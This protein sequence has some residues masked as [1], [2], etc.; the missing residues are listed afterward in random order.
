MPTKSELTS[1]TGLIL[2]RLWF[3]LV[4]IYSKSIRDLPT[5]FGVESRFSPQPLTFH[6]WYPSNFLGLD[7]GGWGTYF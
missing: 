5:I 2:R 1:L 6:L 3:V 4:R 7:S